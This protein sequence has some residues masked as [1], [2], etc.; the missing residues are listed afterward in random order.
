MKTFLLL[1]SL[2]V[3][4]ALLAQTN[5][6]PIQFNGKAFVLPM[7]IK[8]A[9]KKF[10]L[11]KHLRKGNINNRKIVAHKKETHAIAGITFYKKCNTYSKL[12]TL[13]NDYLMSFKKKYK[14]TFK[15]IK[16]SFFTS[17]D[18]KYYYTKIE[19]DL[20]LVIGDVMY[21]AADNNYATVSFFKG[22]PVKELTQCLSILY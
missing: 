16:F 7:S 10:G 2:L 18:G 11:N 8:T 15:P 22:V 13:R 4:P 19:D 1:L 20:I 9:K 14:S 21:N 5:L 6:Q 17:V 12:E 3:S